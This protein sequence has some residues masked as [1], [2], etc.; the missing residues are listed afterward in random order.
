M[1]ESF[2]KQT[3]ERL[4]KRIETM[5]SECIEAA[6][7]GTIAYMDGTG[8]DKILT[9]PEMETAFGDLPFI[10]FIFDRVET[11]EASS[12]NYSRHGVN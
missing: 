9:D 10:V 12:L 1:F 5:R 4:T 11:L 6:R 3:S 2:S 7:K 8:L